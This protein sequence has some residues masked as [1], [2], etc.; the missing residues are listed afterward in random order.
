MIACRK[1]HSGKNFNIINKSIIVIKNCGTEISAKISGRVVY[2]VGVDCE[3]R[4]IFNI[5]RRRCHIVV[6]IK[7]GGLSASAATTAIRT[8][9]SNDSLLTTIKATRTATGPDRE[10]TR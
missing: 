3:S 5:C 1:S 2:D 7:G 8:L 9:N 6:Q 10:S 4:S